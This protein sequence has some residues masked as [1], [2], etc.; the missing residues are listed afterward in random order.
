MP[1]KLLLKVNRNLDYSSS[2]VPTKRLEWYPIT[3]K[4]YFFSQVYSVVRCL[5]SNFAVQLIWFQINPFL[6]LLETG[7]VQN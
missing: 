7:L 5:L 6:N 3:P 2:A 4:A 1:E